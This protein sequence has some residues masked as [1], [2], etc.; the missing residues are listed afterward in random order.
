MKIK[1]LIEKI[2]RDNNMSVQE[3]GEAIGRNGSSLGRS[4]R[5]DALKVRDLKACLQVNGD[6]LLIVYKKNNV[7]IS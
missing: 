6:S 1:E 4:L 7:E 5:D 2:A 3:L